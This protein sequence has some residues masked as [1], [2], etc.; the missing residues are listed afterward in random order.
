MM[1]QK[2]FLHELLKEDQEPFH[3]K[4]YIEDR[5]SQLNKSFPTTTLQL[6]KRKPIISEISTKRSNLC[7]HACF[8]SFQNSPDV[9]KS[10]FFEFPS[11][12][13]RSPCKSP[14]QNGTVFLHIPSR[15]AALLVEAAMRI[16]KQQQ[17][18]TKAQ[19]KNGFGLFGSFL[20]RLK[21]RSKNRKR[22]IGNSDFKVSARNVTEEE[23]TIRISCSCSNRRPSSADWTQ[24]NEDKSL[25]FEAS[26]SSCG[27]ECSG[28]INGDFALSETRFCESPFRFSLHKSPASSGRGTPEFCSPAASPRRH[29]QQ[30]KE[31]YKSRKPEN[32]QEGEEEEEKEQC[33]PVSVLDP[34]FEDDDGHE[35]R[36]TEEDDYDLECT[37]EN[38]QRAKQ[39]LLYRLRRF[40][41]LAELDPMELERKL[42]EGSDDEEQRETEELEDD[43]PLSLYKKH[44]LEKIAA[45]VLN[46][47]SLRNHLK[48]MSTDMKK[49]VSDLIVE[50]KSGTIYS[51]NNEVLMGRICNRLESWKEVEYDTIDMMIGLDLK[52]EFDGWTRFKEQ[53]D[54]TVAEIEVAVFGL[55]M[56]EL[57][58]ELCMC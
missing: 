24:N 13:A 54:E 18:K 34:P 52:R 35:S 16:Q 28:E 36:G 58:E 33:S 22:A 40:E 45:Q 30:E 14:I 9:R 10:P 49:L 7:K 5:R 21:D 6:K 23:A 20:K 50:E 12:A 39:Q 32:A 47:A 38:V 43:D 41:R 25:D 53:V 42:L 46:Q 44:S 55:L 56:D 37:Y 2:Q 19:S 51:G 3:L 1:A 8:F 26:T 29:V 4:S 48:N 11:P 31:N 57:S 15:T 17:G 27:S